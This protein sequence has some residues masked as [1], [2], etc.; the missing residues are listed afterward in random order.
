KP[1]T[2]DATIARLLAPPKPEIRNT[3]IAQISPDS[4]QGSGNGQTKKNIGL[5][6]LTP[7][8]KYNFNPTLPVDEPQQGG[9]QK[10]V[11]R[12]LLTATVVLA[13]V[14]MGLGYYYTKWQTNQSE[15]TALETIQLLRAGKS[16]EEYEECVNQA[17][18]V[19]R[20]SPFYADAQNLLNECQSL[21]Q[22]GKLLAKAKELVQENNLKNAIYEVSKI[23]PDSSYFWSAQQLINQWSLNLIKQAEEVYKQSSNSKGLENAIGITKAIPKTSSVTKNAEKMTE[24]WRIEW[25]KNENYLQASQ[26][27]LKQDKWQEAIDKT[28]KVRLLGQK[29]KQNTPYWQ[30]KIK[31]IIE[32]AQKHIAGAKTPESR[33]NNP[34]A[35]L[36]PQPIPSQVPYQSRPT[37]LY[38]AQQP[39]PYRPRLSVPYQPKPQ[40]RHLY[41]PPVQ[42][43]PQLQV[44]YPP[45]APPKLS[46][47]AQRILCQQFPLNSRCGSNH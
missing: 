32:M 6:E 38:Q 10:E 17:K 44:S 28:N 19:P 5:I 7:T 4:T 25:N 8:E 36:P 47:E 41:K 34:P 21:V 30:N 1:E 43:Q 13:V 18:A 42:S 31:P 37:V 23:Q 45:S 40:V 9:N 3:I 29:V 33:T 2:S 12:L 16:Y 14:S 20:T 39:V 24:N 35:L 11:R 22:E 26:N 15:K 46:P 27:A